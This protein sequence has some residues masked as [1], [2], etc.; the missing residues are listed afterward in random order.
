MSGG[1]RYDSGMKKLAVVAAVGAVLLLGGCA[2]ASAPEVDVT[3]ES[4]PE[5]SVVPTPTG[6]P[7]QDLSD[8]YEPDDLL[9]LI[10][11]K[12]WQ[13]DRPSDDEIIAAGHAACD[14]VAAG[15]TKSAVDVMPEATE[16]NNN[17]LVVNATNIYCPEL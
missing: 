12:G 9:L 5:E 3:S 14:A 17:L 10:V 15:E 8:Q 11:D 13:G 4:A 2:S 16:F 6:T 7:G 1:H